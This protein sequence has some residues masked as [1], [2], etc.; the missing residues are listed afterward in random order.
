LEIHAEMQK[1]PSRSIPIVIMT[2]AGPTASNSIA[3]R[4]S[5]TSSS[6]GR[7]HPDDFAILATLLN[8]VGPTAGHPNAPLAPRGAS[9]GSPRTDRRCVCTAG[10]RRRPS[11][12]R[13][14][15]A[16]PARRVCSR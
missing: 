13:M 2:A 10:T 14:R 16:S 11:R 15:I 5:F 7:S 6:F 3:A 12:R 9:V 4:A 1:D 8:E